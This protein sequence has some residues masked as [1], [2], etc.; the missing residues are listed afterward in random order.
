MMMSG[1]GCHDSIREFRVFTPTE[2]PY[3]PFPN[4]DTQWSPNSGDEV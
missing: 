2:L 3:P 4:I 1:E